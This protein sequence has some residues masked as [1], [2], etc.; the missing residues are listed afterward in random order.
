MG[1][2]FFKVFFLKI[3]MMNCKRRGPTLFT[4]LVLFAYKQRG[5]S[6]CRCN[7]PECN[8]PGEAS[9]CFPLSL[10]WRV[11]GSRWY[12][13]APGSS[14]TLVH[15]TNLHQRQGAPWCISGAT[16]CCAGTM[17][18]ASPA[19][20]CISCTILH[21]SSP[22]ITQLHHITPFPTYLLSPKASCNMWS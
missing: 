7:V 8:V 16:F 2:E 5:P 12:H 14:S 11:Q 6:L 1:L 21:H 22:C 20:Y 19:P 17:M 15:S 3:W 9:P 4:D 13:R 18:A 10:W